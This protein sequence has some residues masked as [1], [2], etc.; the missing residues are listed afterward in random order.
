MTDAHEFPNPGR[1]P[2]ATYK[3]HDLTMNFPIHPAARRHPG[4]ARPL[5]TSNPTATGAPRAGR[6]AAPS[7]A[8]EWAEM[9]ADFPCEPEEA[10]LRGS[11]PEGMVMEIW[12]PYRII[13]LGASG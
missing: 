5:A 8:V 7:A 12:C 1:S 2:R 9:A 13:E 10:A 11:L 3:P 4:R 6:P